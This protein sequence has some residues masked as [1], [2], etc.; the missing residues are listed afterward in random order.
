M[1][2][3]KGLSTGDTH[4]VD[5]AN[6]NKKVDFSFKNIQHAMPRNPASVAPFAVDIAVIGYF[7]PANG[8]VITGPWPSIVA[9]LLRPII[10]VVESH[11]L[12]LQFMELI[13][14]IYQV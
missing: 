6:A 1:G 5:V 13:C 9:R 12:I 4:S 2:I 10:R 8:V 14:L 3:N 7:E 11:F